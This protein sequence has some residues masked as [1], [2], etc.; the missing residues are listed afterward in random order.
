M[1]F[2]KYTAMEYDN[3]CL[4]YR[5][6]WIVLST[7]L[8][9]FVQIK[10]KRSIIH[11]NVVYYCVFFCI[12][13]WDIVQTI[14]SLLRKGGYRGI[15]NNDVR[16]NLRLTRYKSEKITIGYGEYANSKKRNGHLWWRLYSMDMAAINESHD[17]RLAMLMNI[18]TNNM[19]EWRQSVIF[20]MHAWK[21]ID[22]QTF[23]SKTDFA[24]ALCKS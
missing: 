18:L 10:T 13:G 23:C 24:L 20:I 15:I 8:Y 14:D 3:K 5:Y 1:K 12:L 22:V 19:S 9:Y 6:S 21:L 17:P 16:K 11:H 2:W 7:L 4:K